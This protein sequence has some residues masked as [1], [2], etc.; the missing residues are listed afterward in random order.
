MDGNE[1]RIIASTETFIDNSKIG[2]VKP[3]KY[4]TKDDIELIRV[5]YKKYLPHFI[6]KKVRHYDKI[7]NLIEEFSPDVILF[8]GVAAYELMTIIK[9][10]KNNPK[11][12]LFLDSHEDFN[13]SAQ[14]FISREILHR[15]FYSAIVQK[16]LPYVDK[17][18]CVATESFDFLEIMYRVPR[19]KMELFP[20]GGMIFKDSEWKEKRDKIRE[21]LHLGENDILIVHSGKMDINKRT[22]DLLKA[23]IK[24]KNKRF[25][26][27]LIGSFTE[28]VEQSV[29]ASI[30]TDTRIQYLGWKKSS[31]LLE[32]LCAADLYIQPGSQ[33]ATMQNAI[34]CR[35]PVVLYPY[36]SHFPY[37]KGNGFYV[38]TEEDI[39]KVFNTVIKNP[40]LIEKMRKASY[41]VA[42][43]ILDYKKIA[44]RLYQ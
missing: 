14:N 17:I 37:I 13:N 20:L 11:V 44:S 22:E 32:Y 2:Y 18:L 4:F 41:E 19:K 3:G 31:V 35:C 34:C 15:M 16:A 6:M 7:Y 1:V 10:K 24:V 43:N 40:A 33:S 27:V 12:K 38:R 42:C 29:M 9:Y 28:D 23:F 8:H 36:K 25:R 39:K 21:S 26:L 5:P 30:S